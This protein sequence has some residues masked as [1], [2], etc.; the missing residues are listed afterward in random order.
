MHK[1]VSKKYIIPNMYENFGGC[2]LSPGKNEFGVIVVRIF[3]VVRASI[4]GLRA[5]LNVP[6][7]LSKYPNFWIRKY[8]IDL[9]II[10]V[11]DVD[12]QKSRID[13]T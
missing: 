4:P 8:R 12:F 5:V 3:L 1:V 9:V 13:T 6:N 10:H 2:E 7:F 11:C